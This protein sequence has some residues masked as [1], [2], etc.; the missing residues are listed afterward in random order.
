MVS[1]TG[2]KTDSDR[3]GPGVLDGVRVVEITAEP[4]QYSGKMFADLGADVVKVEPPEGDPIR[5]Q[6]PFAQ[7]QPGV[8]RS[9]RWWQFNSGKRSLALDVGCR[10]GRDLLGR[11]IDRAAIVLCS[12]SATELESLGF[13]GSGAVVT[14]I[15]PYGWTGPKRDL[16]APDLIAQADGGLLQ[17]AGLP[18]E[19]PTQAGGRM[20]Y[21]HGS[22]H[23][24]LGT[25]MALWGVRA[26]GRPQHVDVSLQESVAAAV[27]PDIN[28]WDL[29]GV[30]RGREPTTAQRPG[31]GVYRAT[32]GWV[33]IHTLPWYFDQAISWLDERGVV[34]LNGPEWLDPLYR[35]E[36]GAEVKSA[37]AGLCASLDM[38]TLSE[39][40]QAHRSLVFPIFD[41]I[42]VVRDPQVRERGWLEG[43]QQPGLGL[44]MGKGMEVQHPGPP[45]RLSE[46]PWR[47]RR[48]AP[49]LGEHTTEVLAELGVSQ[50]E[51]VALAASGVIA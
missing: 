2:P 11:L 27:Q 14:T 37:F 7:D 46:R 38:R 44:G 16:P 32:D 22:L 40:G 21:V 49:T 3:N 51:R 17:I 15:T 50:A 18:G 8:E 43:V 31:T 41:A 36:H 19:P 20:A 35:V 23:A 9:L 33:G 28:F 1:P 26:G 47:I 25:L 12:G 45:F 48:G 13:S 34:G 4:G 39:E 5:C 24:V 6:A 29:A 10:D 30:V 42:D